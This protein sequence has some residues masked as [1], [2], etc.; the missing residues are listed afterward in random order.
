MRP[1]YVE[2][3]DTNCEK[4]DGMK[5]MFTS[6]ELLPLWVADMDFK[7]PPAVTKALQEYVEM[8]AFGYYKAPESYYQAFIDWE[9]RHHDFAVARE[10]LRFSP[11]VVSGFNWGVQI[12]TLPGESVLIQQPVYYPFAKAVENNGRRLVSADLV[13][14]GGNYRVDLEAFEEK[15]V[16][17]EVKLFILCSPH[18]P[19]GRV[20]QMDELKG[21]IGI[22]R[23]HHVYVLADEIHQD[24]VLPPHKHITAFLAEDYQEGMI[25]LTA[26]SK[27]FN[28]ASGQNSIIIIKDEELRRRWDEFVLTIA[29]GSGNGFGYVAAEAAYREGDEWLAGVI[30]QLEENYEYLKSGLAEHLPEAVLSPLEGTYL[31]WMDLGAYT[32][33]L[34]IVEVMEQK[35]KLA[36]DYGS[37]FAPDGYENYIRINLAT[38]LDNIK[39]A[40]ASLAENL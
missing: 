19:V 15:I 27:T 33:E 30:A 13:N 16:S 3:K 12:L 34:K 25:L 38:C 17:E 18:N 6:E 36:V 2:R 4:W 29:V 37:W 24:L 39:K 40:V 26:P 8:G 7:V 1:E 35:C 14:E 10:W 20:W 32:K 21:M 31:A 22:C 23:K 11:G 28:L 9:W 5:R